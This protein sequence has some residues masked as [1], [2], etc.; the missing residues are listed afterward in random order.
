[1][2]PELQQQLQAADLGLEDADFGY[3]ATDLYVVAKPGVSEF[4]RAKGITTFQGF[5]SQEGSDWNGAGKFCYDIPFRGNW[6]PT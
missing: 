1:M 5:V 4:L 2:K 3:H 6:P